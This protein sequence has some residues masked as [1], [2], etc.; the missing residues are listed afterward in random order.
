[1]NKSV[2]KPSYTI[3][4]P[5]QCWYGSCHYNLG[6][7]RKLRQAVNTI[8]RHLQGYIEAQAL[9]VQNA[10]RLI[11]REIPEQ[12]YEDY[13][14]RLEMGE[15]WYPNTDAELIALAERECGNAS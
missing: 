1:M 3:Y 12:E 9:R 14:F 10:S 4:G 15:T 2:S 13:Y 7:L 8:M 6:L 5:A 11:D